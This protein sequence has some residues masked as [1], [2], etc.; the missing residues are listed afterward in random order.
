MKAILRV[1]ILIAIFM[2]GSTVASFKKCCPSGEVVQVDAI[3]DNNLSPR[4]HFSCVKHSP[5]RSKAKNKRESDKYAMTNSTSLSELVAYNV[6]VDEN[7]HWPSCGENSVLS[8]SALS[9]S[10]KVSQSASCGDIMNGLFFVFACEERLETAK[11]FVDIHKLRKC[12]EK[13]FSFDIFSRRCLNNNGS[14]LNED[15]QE[16]LG[17]KIA[18][19]ES[20]M[21]ECKPDDVLVEYH[22]LVH[23]LMIH[24]SS[25]VIKTMAHHGP[26]LISSYCVEATFNP[27]DLPLKATSGGNHNNNQ[28]KAS[29][30]WIAK[31]CRPKTI[32]AEMPCIRKCCREGFRM[33][34]NNETYCEPH[35]THLSINF[36]FFDVRASPELPNSMEPTG[37]L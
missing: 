9:Q 23:N 13:N 32:C 15:F 30:R 21:P 22:S 36:H 4:R 29:S 11:D 27:E 37:E 20:A 28:L 5:M 10:L 16:I 14:S 19:F 12:C 24:E 3:E 25:L 33:V 18:V 35:D 7:S 1:L 31:V 8:H 17:D 26:D 6:I 34:H 2:I